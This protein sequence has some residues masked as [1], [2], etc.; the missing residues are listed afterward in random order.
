MAVPW[1]FASDIAVVKVMPF[2]IEANPD[3]VT[4][5]VNVSSEIIA[6]R[7][8]SLNSFVMF[9][10]VSPESNIVS[11]VNPLVVPVELG[12]PTNTDDVPL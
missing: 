7:L 3:S 5:G 2:L 10:D 12:G 11:Y 6:I 4:L 1:N 8:P 9:C